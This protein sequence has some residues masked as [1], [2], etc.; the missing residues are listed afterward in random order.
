MVYLRPETAQGI[1][2]NFLNVQSTA[3]QQ[4]PFGI[5]QI[6][7]AF[8][9]EITPGNFT[10]RT[11]EFEQM[12]MQFFVEPGSDPEWFERWR[13]A[14]M[15]WMLEGGWACPPTGCATIRTKNLPTTPARRATSSS[16][17]WDHWG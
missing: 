12:E 8:R 17:R 14:R 5:A 9:N 4:V 11:R 7:K 10:F 13:D 1:Y 3:R 15:R 2:V 6:G 16:F